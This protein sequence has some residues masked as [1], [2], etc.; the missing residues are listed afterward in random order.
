L[1]DENEKRKPLFNDLSQKTIIKV[2]EGTET[3]NGTL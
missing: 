3:G 1:Y 2:Q